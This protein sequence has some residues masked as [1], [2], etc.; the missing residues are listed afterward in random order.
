M[1]K[2][3]KPTKWVQK[4]ACISSEVGMVLIE[5]ILAITIGLIIISVLMEIFLTSQQ[6]SRL[7]SA[8]YSIQDNADAA[9]AILSNEIHQAGMLGCARLTHD[10]PIIQHGEYQL[11]TKNKLLGTTKNAITVRY[12]KYPHSFLKEAMQDDVT[13]HASEQ[14]HFASGDILIISDCNQAEI[15]MAEKVKLKHGIQ[16]ITAST[17]LHNRYK[18]FAEIS[19]LIVN[20]FYAAKTNRKNRDGTPVYAL[21]L[22]DRLHHKSE[23]IANVNQLN[24]AYTINHA[25]QLLDVSSNEVKN[26]AEVLGVAIDLDLQVPPIKKRWHMYAALQG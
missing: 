18:Q 20:T 23:L 1:N 8:L 13:L 5:V 2:I 14:N 9:I 7:Q 19:T 15:F 12:A 21:F 3:V 6:S 16:E 26:W 22:E 4:G 17:P 10:F 24:I 11:T 25:G